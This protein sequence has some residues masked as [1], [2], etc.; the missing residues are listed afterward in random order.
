MTRYKGMV[1]V[2]KYLRMFTA[3][4][5]EL[6]KIIDGMTEQ[7]AKDYLKVIMKE[8]KNQCRSNLPEEFVNL[9]VTE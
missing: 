8:I 2:Q 9:K 6:D 7:Q 5:E 4:E 1:T 3:S